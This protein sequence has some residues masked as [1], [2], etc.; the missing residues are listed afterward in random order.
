MMSIAQRLSNCRAAKYFG[1]VF[2]QQIIF[3]SASGIVVLLGALLAGHFVPEWKI[4]A[5]AVPLALATAA[6]QLRDFARRY[7]FTCSRFLAALLFDTTTYGIQ[8]G[9]LGWLAFHGSLE[10]SDPLWIVLLSAVIGLVGI[11]GQ[12]GKV[13]LER[14]HFAVVLRRHWNFSRWLGASAI[15][16]VVSSQMFL[17]AS[18]FLL[19]TA[20]VG[21]LRA[22][23]NLM[24][25]AQILFYGLQ[26]VI[27]VRAG[28]HYRRDGIPGLLGYLKR[29]S[30]AMLLATGAIVITF[31]AAPEFWLVTIF[32]EQFS[33]NSSLV[34]WYA[35]T[36][37]VVALSF[38]IS[39]G[40]WALEW[41][42]P[43]FVCYA[44]ATIVGAVTAYP[45]IAYFEADGAAAGILLSEAAMVAV[46]LIG[47]V[48]RI[49]HLQS[50]SASGGA[51]RTATK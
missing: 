47:F 46:L 19:G 6:Y 12:I 30:G 31:A 36:Y 23:Q 33:G 14:R 29:M 1:A 43:I 39:G 18:G 5:I 25:L 10:V 50:R 26:N 35:A 20:T 40:L 45:F 17:V 41:T 7:L 11:A 16:Q 49:R 15:V 2:A 34:R 24:G 44:T 9:L 3:A 42:R 22:S 8:L 28:N 37:L 13:S 38:P 48:R 51:V 4:D 27:P 32:G 21:A